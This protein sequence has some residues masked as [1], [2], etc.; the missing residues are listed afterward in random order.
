MSLLVCLWLPWDLSD[1]SSKGQAVG[2]LTLFRVLLMGFFML[3]KCCLFYYSV[4][5]CVSILFLL[6]SYSAAIPFP[7]PVVFLFCSYRVPN[8]FLFCYSVPNLL[9]RC[10]SVPILFLLYYFSESCSY[11]VPIV[12]LFCSYSRRVHPTCAMLSVSRHV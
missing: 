1:S 4:S 7:F 3:K 9:L 11:S 5:I 12:F 8:L 2:R 6:C 10:Y